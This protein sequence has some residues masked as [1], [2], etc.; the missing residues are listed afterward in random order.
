MIPSLEKHCVDYL[1][2][3]LSAKNAWDTLNQCLKWE[4]IPELLDKCKEVLQQKTAEVLKDA[5][6]LSISRD[7]L[8]IL[9]EQN[10]LS[11]AA[12]ELIK[13]VGLDLVSFY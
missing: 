13:S 2:K 5:A 1:V 10:A 3:K 7:C 6:F 11:V 4:V 8:I 12:G 9:L